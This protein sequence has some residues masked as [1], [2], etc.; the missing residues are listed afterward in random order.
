MVSALRHAQPPANSPELRAMASAYSAAPQGAYLLF[1]DSVLFRIYWRPCPPQFP[2]PGR[3]AC[4]PLDCKKVIFPA[5]QSSS[6]HQA[7][8][9]GPTTF[10]PAASRSA[11]SR[12]RSRRLRR[13]SS[14][15]FQP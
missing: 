8:A 13:M 4:H 5:W 2:T 15:A 6:P 7:G 14:L 12:L 11:S 1:R 3:N 10:S 9:H